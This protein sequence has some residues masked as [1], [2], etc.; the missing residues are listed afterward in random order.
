MAFNKAN[1][2]QE[3]EKLVSQGKI[4]QAIKQYN[5]VLEKDPTEVSLLNSIGDLYYRD[6]NVAAALKCF[7]KLADAFV[8]DGFTVK[9]IAIYRKISKIDPNSVE[10]FI[11]LAELYGL[12]G[13]S[14]EAREQYAQAVEFYRKKNQTDNA[15]EIFR[16]IVALD[17]ENKTYHLRL[18]EYAE[19][20]G[21]KEEAASAYLDVAEVAFRGGDSAAGE[22]ALKKALALGAESNRVSLLQARVA[23]HKQE[24][25]QVEKIVDSTPELKSSAPGRQLL[26][27][28]YLAAQKLEMAEKLVVD[29]FSA[30]P[31]DF[32]PVASFSGLCIK[33]G[34]VDAVVKLLGE[35]AD[36]L[37]ERKETA[38]AMEILRQIWAK[39][40]GHLA[41][42]ELIHRI[43]KATADEFALPEVL[44]ALGQAYEQ[45]GDLERAEAV[46]RDLVNRVP[47]NENYQNLLNE[48]LQK[49]GKE[50]PVPAAVALAG[51]AIEVP[52]EAEAPPAA[53]AAEAAQAEMVKEALENSDLFS[54]YNL[55]DK[56]VGE[57]EKVLAVYPEQADIQRRILEL[58]HRSQPARARV[59]AEALATI[60]TKQGDS[61][62]AKK[63]QD[64]ATQLA[65][66]VPAPEIPLPPVAV[67]APPPP[68]SPPPAPRPAG[69]EF[70]LSEVFPVSAP[71]EAAK[72]AQ[73]EIS[74]DL[75]APATVPPPEVPPQELELPAESEALT[76]T[77]EAPVVEREVPPFN[78]EEARVEI[79]FYLGQGLLEE[80]HSA[81]QALEEKFP[82]DSCVA[83]LRQRLEAQ[84]G[85]PA[86][87]PGEVAPPPTEPVEATA[88]EWE[89]P[90][91][92]AGPGPAEA[93]PE[94]AP[95]PVEAPVPPA[96]SELLP[97]PPPPEAAVGAAGPSSA[98]A[99]PAGS[100]LLGSLV[101]ELEA[102]LEGFGE[103]T[104]PP[105]AER[106]AEAP[107]AQAAAPGGE[108][109]SLFSGL[110][111]ELGE[112]AAAPEAEEDQEKHYNLGV[113]FREMGLLDEAIGEFQK[114]V[115]GAQKDKFPPNFLQACSLLAVCF[116]DKGMPAIAA[117]WYKRALELPDLDDESTLA[118]QYDLGVAYEQAGDTRS[119]L[120]R[121]SEVYSQNIDY[122]DVAEKIR[123][124]QK[125]AP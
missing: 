46:Y 4:A 31:A 108:A 79:D 124:L 59:A 17:P 54:R 123:T 30:N 116:T 33:K 63:Y 7:H 6:K 97:P 12:Q 117:K 103:P 96:V 75:S 9:A 81:I 51:V 29:V 28:A 80:A 11:K 69:M 67:E 94:V 55:V 65:S 122:R 16:K 64:L 84:A 53:P 57:L 2:M 73:G 121:F 93:A 27:E 105:A 114:V 23:L 15:L 70:D 82:G 39:N 107:P 88:A 100:D 49:Q 118:L 47:G 76:P 48:V 10:P 99:P 85:A 36:V 78:Y 86:A 119:A 120:E 37:I 26:L 111:E 104:P 113:A 3:A 125:K 44:G 115:K 62:S 60:H 106:A 56:A 101:G 45:S 58:C 38:P 13:L 66:G 14:R 43:C 87:A 74:L 32:S 19:Q 5:L 52:P 42:L 24:Y 77:A 95:P 21:R 90:A 98:E 34:N 92:F 35:V 83:E 25:G 91:T 109:A 72:E 68:P 71:A 89:L 20:S 8:R 61:A 40:P 102:G 112:G 110:L 50:V 18:A 22:P 1:A 41:A